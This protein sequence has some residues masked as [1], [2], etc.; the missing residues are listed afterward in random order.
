MPYK[1]K[2]K[3]RENRIR[4]YHEVV[5]LRPLTLEQKES[6]LVIERIR[7]LKRRQSRKQLAINLHG[8]QCADC[9]TKCHP[10]CYDFHHL[11]PSQKDFN[12]CSGL[13]KKVEV[14]LA[15]VAKCIML[16][17]NCHR[18]RHSLYETSK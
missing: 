12:P 15:E 6:Q 3:S 18:V 7:D 5:K 1:D 10:A 13:S 17:A 8:N 16:C 2:E 14:F 11:D 9:K 4:Y